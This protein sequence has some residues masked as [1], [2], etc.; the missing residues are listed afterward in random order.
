MIEAVFLLLGQTDYPYL[1]VM[2]TDRLAERSLPVNSD[3][4][5]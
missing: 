1:R 2:Y 3:V 5:F 4:S